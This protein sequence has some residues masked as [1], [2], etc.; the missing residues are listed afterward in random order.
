MR[1]MHL[2]GGWPGH[3]AGGCR[4]P[5]SSLIWLGGDQRGVPSPLS[6]VL[7]AAGTSPPSSPHMHGLTGLRCPQTHCGDWG[8]TVGK[9]SVLRS[10]FLTTVMYGLRE[11]LSLSRLQA[12]AL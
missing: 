9:G 1:R 5:G 2:K 11:G 8:H 3:Q 6:P 4:H 10:R 12:P 7:W